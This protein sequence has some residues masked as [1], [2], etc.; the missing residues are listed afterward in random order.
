MPYLVIAF[1]NRCVL[2]VLETSSPAFPRQGFPYLDS[3]PS[4][5]PSTFPGYRAIDF[6]RL[7]G[8]ASLEYRFLFISGGL[9]WR[10]D[11]LLCL[12]QTNRELRI[13]ISSAAL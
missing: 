5:S 10:T 11:D 6:R 13:D 9:R 3:L 12:P 4:A 2:P 7:Q 8:I 1:K